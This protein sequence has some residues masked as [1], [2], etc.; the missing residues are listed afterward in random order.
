M[1]LGIEGGDNDSVYN[2]WSYCMLKFYENQGQIQGGG[3]SFW[4]TPNFIRR[5]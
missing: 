4:G 2:S 5:E 3:V 1:G